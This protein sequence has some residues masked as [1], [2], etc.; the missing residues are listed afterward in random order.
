[1]IERAH[2]VGKKP[3]VSEAQNGDVNPRRSR[4]III[5]FGSWKSKDSVLKAARERAK[6]RRENKQTPDKVKVSE[7]YSE[8]VRNTRKALAEI[9]KERKEEAKENHEEINCYLRFDKLVMN[10]IVYKL[11]E[12]GELAYA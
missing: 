4:P 3:E 8:D 2:R 6:Q 5:K 12:N 11:N 10:D 7:D 1:M 9:M